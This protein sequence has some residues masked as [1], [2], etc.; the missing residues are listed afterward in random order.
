MQNLITKTNQHVLH[1]KEI[2]EN[3][4]MLIDSEDELTETEVQ[5]KLL[6]TVMIWKYINK[7]KLE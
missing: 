5:S 4:Y 1:K 2:Y 3:N 7:D 6:K